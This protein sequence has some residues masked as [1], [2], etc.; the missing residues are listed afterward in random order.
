[1]APAPCCNPSKLLHR[2][3][4]NH[5]FAKKAVIIHQSHEIELEFDY[6]D[7]DYLM[8][9]MVMVPVMGDHDKHAQ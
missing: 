2:P 3:I 8:M 5:V 6:D 7:D 1:M 4:S 9:M